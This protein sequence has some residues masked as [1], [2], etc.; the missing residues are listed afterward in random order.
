MARD[1]KIIILG[2]R[3]ENIGVHAQKMR[4]AVL[5]KNPDTGCEVHFASSFLTAAVHAI[6][7]PLPDVIYV[8]NEGVW[9]KT[10]MREGAARLA[11]ALPPRSDAPWIVL[12]DGLEFLKTIFKSAGI[13]VVHG[14]PGV[15]LIE[16]Y[17]QFRHSR[18]A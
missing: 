14:S 1:V 17:I 3:P 6:A 4:R 7:P 11:Q 8:V 5:E 15:A 18:A 10:T 16:R 13:Y 2:H 12:D 9:N